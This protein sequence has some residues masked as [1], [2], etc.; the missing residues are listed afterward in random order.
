MPMLQSAAILYTPTTEETSILGPFAKAL[1]ERGYKVGGIVQEMLFDEDGAKA[2]LDAIEV[3]TGLRIPI[4]RPTKS[5]KANGTCSLDHAALAES[6]SAIRRAI[7]NRMDL[8]VIE[9]YGDQEKKGG[10]LADE[11]LA[12]MAEGIP[13]LT[14][15][16]AISLEEWNRFSG[17]LT[18]LLPCSEEAIWAWWDSSGL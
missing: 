18:Q 17:G 3:D 5:D 13:V 9:K 7:E 10:G 4:N 11:I 15:V 6:T 2:G 16:P 8:I 12:A 1:N 14:L